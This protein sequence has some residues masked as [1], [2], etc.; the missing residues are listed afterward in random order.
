MSGCTKKTINKRA[1][2][3]AEKAVD[4]GKLCEDG[5]GHTLRGGWVSG[6]GE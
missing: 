4:G 1:S 6:R 3:S 2:K 5:I